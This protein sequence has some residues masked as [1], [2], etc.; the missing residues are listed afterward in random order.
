MASYKRNGTRNVDAVGLRKL[1]V[2]EE[3][4]ALQEAYEDILDRLVRG[5]DPLNPE[6]AAR[7]LN[8]L[9]T[10]ERVPL[11]TTVG[12]HDQPRSYHLYRL[13]TSL[14]EV[15]WSTECDTDDVRARL[16]DFVEA[17]ARYKLWDDLDYFGNAMR[18]ELDGVFSHKPE[19]TSQARISFASFTTRLIARDLFWGLNFPA[20]ELRSTL[21]KPL[22]DANTSRID[23]YLAI[24]R[25]YILHAGVKTYNHLRTLERDLP[26]LNAKKKEHSERI[27]MAWSLYKE[28]KGKIFSVERWHFWKQRI[29][30]LAE[31]ASPE[32]QM[33]AT[34][35]V[36]RMNQIEMNTPWDGVV[37]DPGAA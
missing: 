1:G 9:T 21:E 24:V 36:A 30:E 37:A 28:G 2:S 15:A 27:Y 26:H 25:E 8:E 10:S 32:Y 31:Q 29:A 13:A 6:E 33:I 22:S 34:G 7:E 17:L 11:T 16:V 23:A 4:I 35:L 20:W 18:E 5:Q 14:T 3:N 19:G 12:R